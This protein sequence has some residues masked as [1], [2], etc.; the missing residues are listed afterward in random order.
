MGSVKLCDRIIKAGR[1]LWRSRSLS[2]FQVK[3]GTFPD[4]FWVSLMAE[5]VGSLFLH[6]LP[7][8]WGISF[9]ASCDNFIFLLCI[10]D[11]SLA[12]L[13]LAITTSSLDFSAM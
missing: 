12:L 4:E 6:L 8:Q 1:N 2:S 13:F 3:A 7:L 5:P 10:F 9:A 11:E